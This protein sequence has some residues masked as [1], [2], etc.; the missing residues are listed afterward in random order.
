MRARVLP[1]SLSGWHPGP[2]APARSTVAPKLAPP[3]PRQP[4]ARSVPPCAGTATT[5]CAA[6]ERP[7]PR[8]V[9]AVPPA[10]S[11]RPTAL[12]RDLDC[13]VRRLGLGDDAP[14][15][16]AIVIALRDGVPLR[17]ALE[18]LGVD[19]APL[20]LPPPPE[21][22][23]FSRIASGQGFTWKG[24]VWTRAALHHALAATPERCDHPRVVVAYLAATQR[25][26]AATAFRWASGEGSTEPTCIA[27]RVEANESV[28]PTDPVPSPAVPEPQAAWTS[29]VDQSP[30]LGR[31]VTIDAPSGPV[32][33]RLLYSNEAAG[34]AAW[35]TASGEHLDIDDVSR[36]RR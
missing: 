32:A 5:R 27:E 30:E 28:A 10:A 20:D 16:I 34:G 15:E 3:G 36:W 9:P 13:L 21:A 19:T 25:G 7:A 2:E 24:H 12:R 26:Q 11:L 8:I 22:V 1:P 6:P 29:M 17:D 23:P 14:R 33:A 18:R 4:R 35:H 31:T